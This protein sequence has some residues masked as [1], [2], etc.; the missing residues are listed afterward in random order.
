M[1][2]KV[3]RLKD[4]LLLN[5]VYLSLVWKEYDREIKSVKMGEYYEELAHKD[6]DNF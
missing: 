1:N 4:T 6:M 5:L 2:R 3:A